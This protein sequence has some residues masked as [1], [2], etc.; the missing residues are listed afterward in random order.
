MQADTHLP[1][2]LLS[3]ALHSLPY[4]PHPPIIIWLPD[5]IL[6]CF[7]LGFCTYCSLRLKHSFHSLWDPD[8]SG[9]MHFMCTGSR[10]FFFFFAFRL[11]SLSFYLYLLLECKLHK[12]RNHMCVF[13][14]AVSSA[15]STVTCGV[16][17]FPEIYFK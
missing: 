13:L 8:F 4:T 5:C 3:P 7:I 16:I 1:L 12:G 17:N 15:D 11:C 10:N 9:F 14:K 6:F 2:Q